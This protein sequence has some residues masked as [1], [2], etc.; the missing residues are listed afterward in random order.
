MK[1]SRKDSDEQ[2]KEVNEAFVCED[3]DFG[4][5]AIAAGVRDERV[6]DA[7]LGVKVPE[8]LEGETG[9]GILKMM[10]GMARRVGKRR[11]EVAVCSSST[12]EMF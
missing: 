3:G 5:D 8:V 10:L 4:L 7:V 1:I 9:E 2:G 12:K 11:T 6:G